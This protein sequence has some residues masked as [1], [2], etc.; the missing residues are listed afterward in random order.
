M[1]ACFPIEPEGR[2][3]GIQS[4]TLYVLA[5]GRANPTLVGRMADALLA[6]DCGTA[7]TVPFGS[8]VQAGT[9]TNR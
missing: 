1:N 8:T 6:R 9:A 7:G 2:E 5:A 3:A 4:L